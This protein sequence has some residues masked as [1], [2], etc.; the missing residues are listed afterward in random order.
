[1]IDLLERIRRDYNN[2]TALTPRA[3]RGHTLLMT[4]AQRVRLWVRAHPETAA[5]WIA[6]VVLRASS[7]TAK[8]LWLDEAMTLVLARAPLADIPRLVR[9]NELLPPLHYALMHAWLLPFA[10]P[11]LGLRSFSVLCGLGALAAFAASARRLIP[12]QAPLAFALAAFSSYWIDVAQSGRP[13]ALFL[14]LAAVAFDLFLRLRDRWRM[15]P[16]L[17]YAA[18]GLL[19]LY[20]H[21]YFALALGAQL[22]WVVHRHRRRP[23]ALAPWLWTAAFWL[24]GFAPWA[25][26]VAAQLAIYGGKPTLREPFGL[27]A[28]AALFG[29]FF[30]NLSVLSFVIG[31]WVKAV[32]AA[33]LLFFLSAP[34]LQKRLETREKDE[35]GLVASQLALPLLAAELAELAL[36]RP[37]TQP[38]YFVFLAVPA[39]LLAALL[40]GR[41][42]RLRRLAATAALAAVVACGAAGYAYSCLVLDPRL[43]LLA[44]RLRAS[45]VPGD[46]VVHV[47]PFYYPSLRYHYLPELP[48]YILDDSSPM[49]NWHALPGYDPVIPRADLSRRPRVLIVDPDRRL[50]DRRAAVADGARLAQ[51]ADAQRA[52]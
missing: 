44:A 12:R 2:Y 10:D 29:G 52:R 8:S 30:M 5:L 9:T 14:L 23:A 15:G 28:L 35:L 4:A 40:V 25:P 49:L 6:A 20:T 45:A 51:W 47:N 33:V 27:D 50:S 31:A 41:L 26:S 24:A 1:M 46:I 17:A 34:L 11:V 18:V 43:G 37:M 21:Y 48:H 36:G 16:G 39:Y 38:R 19:G 7:L 13:Y 42:P 22:A 3:R 32:G